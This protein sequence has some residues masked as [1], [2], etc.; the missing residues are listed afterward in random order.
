[1]RHRRRSGDGW[2]GPP[3]MPTAWG[4]GGVP[5]AN[6]TMHASAPWVNI[7]V[8]CGT[9]QV[10]HCGT[11]TRSASLAR[12]LKAPV[13]AWISDWCCCCARGLRV[14]GAVVY[15]GEGREGGGARGSGV[16]SGEP[17]YALFRWGRVRVRDQQRPH[18][19]PRP[20]RR[21]PGT[22]DGRFVPATKMHSRMPPC[23]YAGRLQ[24]T[25][26][27]LAWVLAQ[28]DGA[29]PVTSSSTWDVGL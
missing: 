6:I 29:Q 3:H 16:G 12:F 10:V 15:R 11:R 7:A 17:G 4:A 27:R 26:R 5:H 21:V 19:T 23:L 14:R 2:H 18:A 13:A 28:C 24:A 20:V 8:H 9:L 25:L 22:R 1:M